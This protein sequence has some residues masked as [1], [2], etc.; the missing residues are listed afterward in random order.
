MHKSKLSAEQKAEI[1]RLYFE[2]GESQCFIAKRYGIDEMAVYQG[3]SH[4]SLL[5]FHTKRSPS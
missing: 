5:S 4:L 3:Y 1:I 2:K